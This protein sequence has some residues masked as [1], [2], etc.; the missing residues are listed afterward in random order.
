MGRLGRDP[1]QGT[2]ARGP[3]PF[4]PMT[5][6]I[7]VCV[8]RVRRGLNKRGGFDAR[9]FGTA[10]ERSDETGFCRAHVAAMRAKRERNRVARGPKELS[11]NDLPFAGTAD[12]F[13]R[14]WQRWARC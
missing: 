14:K 9:A 12:I 7:Q 3:R 6:L 2:A 4:T 5:A 1:S 8:N 13:W 10:G 11:K